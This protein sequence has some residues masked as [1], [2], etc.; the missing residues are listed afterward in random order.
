MG[1]FTPPD[2]P[3]PST[4]AYQMTPAKIS[5]H[6]KSK[7]AKWEGSL[8]ANGINLGAIKLG[9]DSTF[10]IPS[11]DVVIKVNA[12]KSRSNTLTLKGVQAGELI[13]L[14]CEVMG[15]VFSDASSISTG[16]AGCIGVIIVLLI[17]GILDTLLP[18]TVKLTRKGKS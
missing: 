12:P 16:Q 9:D 6:I 10:D 4:V 15:T 18:T 3:M 2:N 7:S 13:D 14:E 17:G 5:V 11:G 8:E 1:S